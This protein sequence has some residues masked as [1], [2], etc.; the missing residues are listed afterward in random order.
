MPAGGSLA[1][2]LTAKKRVPLVGSLEAG[3]DAKGRRFDWRLKICLLGAL[4]LTGDLGGV[5]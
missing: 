5:R 2:I 1:E 3:R 4:G